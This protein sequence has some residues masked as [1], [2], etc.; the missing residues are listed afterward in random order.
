MYS[1]RNKDNFIDLRD[2][3]CLE[4][5]LNAL[6]FLSELSSEKKILIEE[7]VETKPA[8]EDF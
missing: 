8:Q 1:K 7:D 6:E 4:V 2:A 5:I 3:R